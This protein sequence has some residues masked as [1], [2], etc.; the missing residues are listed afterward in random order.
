MSAS[1]V[2]WGLDLTSAVL[3][4]LDPLVGIH[5]LSRSRES[6]WTSLHSTGI[7]LDNLLM[8]FINLN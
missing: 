2:P 4:E 3:L 7:Y 5:S 8:L 1:A 6:A